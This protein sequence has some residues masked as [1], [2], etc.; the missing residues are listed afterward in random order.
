[1]LV[2]YLK[3][4]NFSS[5]SSPHVSP[6]Y[7]QMLCANCSSQFAL[8]SYL[9]LLFHEIVG[10]P[11]SWLFAEEKVR[12]KLCLFICYIDFT[13]LGGDLLMWCI[14]DSVV[15]SCHH[16]LFCLLKVRVFY[17]VRLFLGLLSVITET[18]LVVALSRKYGKRLASYALAMLCLTSGCFFASTSKWA[19]LY[20]KLW[21]L[22]IFILFVFMHLVMTLTLTQTPLLKQTNWQIIVDQLLCI[23]KIQ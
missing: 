3:G 10:R 11:A 9:Y 18:V 19:L 5:F 17:A 2:N 15:H 1:M 7:W 14:F 22:T 16:C 20:S 8:R 6:W 12:F 4:E 23:F 21:Y 13:V